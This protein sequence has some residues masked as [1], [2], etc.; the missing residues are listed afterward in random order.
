M[1][2]NLEHLSE[3]TSKAAQDPAAT[4]ELPKEQP[5][6]PLPSDFDSA[7]STA[8]L[9]GYT[10]TDARNRGEGPTPEHRGAI[11]NQTPRDPGEKS[12]RWL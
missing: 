9:Y 3:L 5:Q 6:N 7:S 2:Q 11:W 10:T 8:D 12:G 4:P 1:A